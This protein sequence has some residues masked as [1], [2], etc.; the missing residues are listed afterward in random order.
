MILTTTDRFNKKDAFAAV[1]KLKQEGVLPPTDTDKLLNYFAPPAP[2]KPKFAE[3][4]VAL[5]CGKKDVRA[6]VNLLHVQRG[7]AHGMDGHRMHWTATEL[8]DGAYCPKTLIPVSF[9][10]PIPDLDRVKGTDS[11]LTPVDLLSAPVRMSAG[12]KPARCRSLNGVNVDAGYL[13][14]AALGGDCQ[15][16]AD[17]SNADWG[18]RGSTTFGDFRIMGARI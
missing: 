2:K 1:L 4:W 17:A 15:V 6:W 14:A 18:V 7:V 10:D 16:Y 5:A 13:D 8:P 3:Q 12:T 11:G 9:D